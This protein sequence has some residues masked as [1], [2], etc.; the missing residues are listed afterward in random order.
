MTRTSHE[1]TNNSTLSSMNNSLKVSRNAAKAA[2]TTFSW[3][4]AVR[5]GSSAASGGEQRQHNQTHNSTEQT[6]VIGGLDETRKAKQQRHTNGDNEEEAAG[7]SN[8]HLSESEASD[9]DGDDEAPAGSDK[10]TKEGTE[11]PASKKFNLVVNGGGRVKSMLSSLALSGRACRV[12]EN[13][14]AICY[15]YGALTCHTCRIF[16]LTWNKRRFKNIVCCDEQEECDIVEQMR[17]TGRMCTKCRLSKC[18]RVGMRPFDRTLAS[19]LFK[20]FRIKREPLALDENATAEAAAAPT[21]TATV[22]CNIDLSTTSSSSATSATAAT[23]N[24]N[25]ALR[26]PQAAHKLK[27]LQSLKASSA[28]ASSLIAASQSQ[29][30]QS[31]KQAQHEEELCVICELKAVDGRFYGLKTCYSCKSFYGK[32]L[33]YNYQ[34]R[35]CLGGDGRCNNAMVLRCNNCRFKRWTKKLEALVNEA[36]AGGGKTAESVTARSARLRN[37]RSM[38]E[39]NDGKELNESASSRSKRQTTENSHH[40]HNN[41]NKDATSES[42]IKQTSKRATSA[43]TRSS[44]SS[45]S[46]ALLNKSSATPTTRRLIA[47]KKITGSLR[48]RHSLTNTSNK[49]CEACQYKRAQCFHYGA[50]TCSNCSSFFWGTSKRNWYDLKCSIGDDKC[51]EKGINSL[52]DCPKCRLARC[53][54]GGMRPIDKALADYTLEYMRVNNLLVEVPASHSAP[55][56]ADN[57]AAEKPNSDKHQKVTNDLLAPK[58]EPVDH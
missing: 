51:A 34:A 42:I 26:F 37:K 11:K 10:Q 14:N 43:T 35:P 58:S 29:K 31:H 57:Q 56:D 30:Q 41:N 46:N 3:T 22:V 54:L 47:S 45:N 21:T 39:A 52:R 20:S 38:L 24:T 16:F 50:I 23:K 49:M 2:L 19:H 8:L 15:N 28:K 9:N 36:V 40:N 13:S 12:C 7:I 6:S 53:L 1:E 5:G 33:Y 18:L 44:L 17:R 4:P 48:R 27:S 55:A 32:R 25:P